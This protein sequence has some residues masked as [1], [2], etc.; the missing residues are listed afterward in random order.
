MLAISL[1]IASI[2]VAG[3]GTATAAPPNAIVLADRKDAWLWT[4]TLFL[5]WS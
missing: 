5:I 1:G 4:T 2:P 3:I